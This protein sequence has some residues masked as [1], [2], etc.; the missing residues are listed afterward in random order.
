[1]LAR[2]RKFHNVSLKFIRRYWKC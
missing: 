2:F 1:M